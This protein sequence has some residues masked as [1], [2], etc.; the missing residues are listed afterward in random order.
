VVFATS[1]AARRF[2]GVGL[3]AFA[4]QQTRGPGEEMT[5]K[6]QGQALTIAKA[7][8]TLTPKYMMEGGSCQRENWV[9][10]SLRS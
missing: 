10:W 1:V 3:A 4:A 7:V 2:Y 5:K 9:S 6:N 8:D